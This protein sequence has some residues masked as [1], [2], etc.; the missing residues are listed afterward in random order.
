MSVIG[1]ESDLIVFEGMYISQIHK[2]P[3]HNY[4]VVQY[5]VKNVSL[6]RYRIESIS[7]DIGQ[8]KCE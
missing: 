4:H 7:Y 8:L 3:D 2:Q 1:I 5:G 6:L